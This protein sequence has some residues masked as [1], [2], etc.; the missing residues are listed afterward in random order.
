MHISH[1]CL[2]EDKLL[3]LA[4]GY[5][6]FRIHVVAFML[7]CERNTRNLNASITGTIDLWP[8]NLLV[9]SQALHE[10]AGM[11]ARYLWF[12]KHE[13]TKPHITRGSSRQ[14]AGHRHRN[15][16]P[17]FAAQIVPDCLARLL[18]KRVALCIALC[19]HLY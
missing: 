6:L 5:D 8:N 16:W 19:D 13:Y 10:K 18:G 4:L 9:K 11:Q 1:L 7:T 2:G 14:R 17:F 3:I 12:A 15:V